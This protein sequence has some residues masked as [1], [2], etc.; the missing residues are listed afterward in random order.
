LVGKAGVAFEWQNL[1]ENGDIKNRAELARKERV[2]RACVT[3]ILD[4][5]N[6]IL[7]TDFDAGKIPKLILK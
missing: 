5:K 3:Q 4:Y 7:T 2:S 6:P 1:I